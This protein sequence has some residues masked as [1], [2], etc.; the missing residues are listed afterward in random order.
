MRLRVHL[1]SFCQPPIMETPVPRKIRRALLPRTAPALMTPLADRRKQECPPAP[2]KRPHPRASSAEKVV[3]NVAPPPADNLPVP[4]ETYEMMARKYADAMVRE[5]KAADTIAELFSTITHQKKELEE[6]KE[7][8]VRL[9]AKIE[10]R[11]DDFDW[12]VEQKNKAIADASVL[13]AKRLRTMRQILGIVCMFDGCP[14][15]ADRQAPMMRASKC[16]CSLPRYG[17]AH[18]IGRAANVVDKGKVGT[19]CSICRKTVK[20]WSF[21]QE[22]DLL[23]DRWT[24]A[25]D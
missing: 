4:I 25:S 14:D 20:S 10:A 15:L 22:V 11:D 23:P 8:E 3:E 12:A 2:R 19:A 16:D 1:S 7:K 21:V 24:I 13:L 5:K 17:C 18:C 9:L 6:A